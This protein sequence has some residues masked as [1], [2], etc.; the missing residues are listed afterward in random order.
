MLSAFL[1]K[2]SIIGTLSLILAPPII[3]VKG[4]LGLSNTTLKF[5][6]SFSTKKPMPLGI[7]EAIPTLEA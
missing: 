6:I 5:L 7:L 1:A 3:T 4:L 2:A